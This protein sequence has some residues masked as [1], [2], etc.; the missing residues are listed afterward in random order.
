MAAGEVVRLL[1]FIRSIGLTVWLDG[2]WGV[3]ALLEEQRADLAADLPGSS[4]RQPARPRDRGDFDQWRVI[5]V[6]TAVRFAA[7]DP[8]SADRSGEGAA[9]SGEPPGAARDVVVFP[10][11]NVAVQ[12]RRLIASDIFPRSRLTM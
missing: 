4:E 2:G 5:R 12:V 7:R 11:L 3:N 10:T 8:R 1:E 9:R 6:A